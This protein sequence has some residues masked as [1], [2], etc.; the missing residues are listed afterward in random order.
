M[1]MSLI[2]I[3]LLLKNNT[4][5]NTNTTKILHRRYPTCVMVR[6]AHIKIGTGPVNISC[7]VAEIYRSLRECLLRAAPRADGGG[8]VRDASFWAGARPM[9]DTV[10]RSVETAGDFLP[11][12]S[13]VG[14]RAVFRERNPPSLVSR[15]LCLA[16]LTGVH[17][18][19][20]YPSFGC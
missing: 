19:V 16:S 18:A 3:I 4:N 5:N 8:T 1:Q 14:P 17:T 10:T 2:L 11:L 7:E 13:S 15:R 12:P 6:F 20:Q 9:G